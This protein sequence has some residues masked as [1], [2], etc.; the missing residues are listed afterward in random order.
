MTI[1]VK[2]LFEKKPKLLSLDAF[3]WNSNPVCNWFQGCKDNNGFLVIWREKISPLLNKKTGDFDS[4]F[5][6]IPN[7]S[8]CTPVGTGDHVDEV[9][10]IATPNRKRKSSTTPPYL[11]PTSKSLRMEEE[12]AA[13]CDETDMDQKIRNNFLG[14]ISCKSCFTCSISILL[15]F[16]MLPV[17]RLMEPP[18]QLL[19]RDKKT[20]FIEALKQEM[21]DN[22]LGDVQPILCV[23]QLKDKEK[24]DSKMKEAY[25]YYTIGGNHSREALQQILSEKPELS[26]NRT[27]T[28]RL[29]SIYSK[30]ESH[31]LIRLASKHNRATNFSHDM[32]AWDRVSYNNYYSKCT[33]LYV[34]F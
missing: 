31:L 11:L 23:V 26:R 3:S 24:F 7:S 33:C 9:D 16:Y 14:M 34:Y 19:V 2:L 5:E 20:V 4:S 30:M 10:D 15:G 25:T 6:D 32:T 28:H 27:Y 1:Q 12:N 22:P 8:T 18:K 13:N 17:C 29:C 21:L